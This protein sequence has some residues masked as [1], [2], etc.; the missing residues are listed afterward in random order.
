MYFSLNRVMFIIYI[1]F[2]KL[3]S[4]IMYILPRVGYIQNYY[5]HDYIIV[6][7]RRKLMS[8]ISADG[9]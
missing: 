2:D 9:W 8:S 1:I 7:S 4:A 3:K 6:A 5:L